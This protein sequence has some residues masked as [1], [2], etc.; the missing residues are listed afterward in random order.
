[1]TFADMMRIADEG[2]KPL[3]L[4]TAIKIFLVICGVI[5]LSIGKNSFVPENLDASGDD[6]KVT[7]TDKE[8]KDL[9]TKRKKKVVQDKKHE[10]KRTKENDK[11]LLDDMKDFKKRVMER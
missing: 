10:R 9:E 8:V 3:N 2:K 5:C 11:I 4:L 7:V 1:M 6:S